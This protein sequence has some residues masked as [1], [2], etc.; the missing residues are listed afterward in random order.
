MIVGIGRFDFFFSTLSVNCRHEKVS[1][2][3]LAT[4]SSPKPNPGRVSAYLLPRAFVRSDVRDFLEQ[5]DGSPTA[6]AVFM[7]VGRKS[8]GTPR[9]GR[10]IRRIAWGIRSP[11]ADAHVNL[12]RRRA[13]TSRRPRVRRLDVVMLIV[14]SIISV[15]EKDAGISRNV[16][17]EK[18]AE[19]S[20]LFPPRVCT[21]RWTRRSSR[22]ER[23]V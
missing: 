19:E 7:S 3:C 16:A 1:T 11:G 18:F 23:A 14:G 21:V 5:S 17:A 13:Q 20:S 2:E 4:S 10:R 15:R 6:L 8:R 22:G 12:L 9:R